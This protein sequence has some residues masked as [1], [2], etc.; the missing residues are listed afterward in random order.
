MSVLRTD[1]KNPDFIKL[2]KKLDTELA[3]RDGED[4]AFY[5][6]FNKISKLK[7]VIVLYLDHKPVS[8]GAIKGFDS[9]SVEVKRMFTVPGYRRQGMARKVLAELEKWASELSYEKCVL[10]TGRRQPEAIALYKK[11]GYQKIPNYGQYKGIENSLCFEKQL[12]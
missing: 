1:S 2:V 6:Q 10:E 3:E 5:D 9:S 12:N 8:C 11:N 4:H 7:H